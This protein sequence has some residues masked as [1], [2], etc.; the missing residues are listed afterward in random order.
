MDFIKNFCSTI[1]TIEKNK[2]IRHNGE[3]ISVKYIPDKGLVRRIYKKPP[4]SIIK[5][6]TIQLKKGAKD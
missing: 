4:S 2:K 6:Q 5:K 3:K 1:G